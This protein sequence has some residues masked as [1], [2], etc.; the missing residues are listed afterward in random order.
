MSN[1]KIRKTLKKWAVVFIVGLLAIAV[2]LVI[3]IADKRASVETT[4]G[5]AMKDPKPEEKARMY[6]PV[7][8][9]QFVTLI[10]SFH[11]NHSATL[12]IGDPICDKDESITRI[13]ISRGAVF[14]RN[15]NTETEWCSDTLC[16][17]P[18]EAKNDSVIVVSCPADLMARLVE[19]YEISHA[20][21]KTKK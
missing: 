6:V 1:K 3:V 4:K 12:D 7:E 11:Q 19:D 20:S 13:S 15:K 17:F 9:S 8:Y 14:F 21:N 5:Y 2:I 16:S 18:T 10:R